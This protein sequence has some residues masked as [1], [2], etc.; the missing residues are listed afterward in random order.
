MSDWDKNLHLIGMNNIIQVTIYNY[1]MS[2]CNKKTDC[3]FVC[4]KIGFSAGYKTYF[5]KM[6]LK[7]FVEHRLLNLM[8]LNQVN[9]KSSMASVPQGY[10]VVYVIHK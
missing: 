10:I 9:S 1:Y 2:I 5:Y 4:I 6:V 8:V 7:F 3:M